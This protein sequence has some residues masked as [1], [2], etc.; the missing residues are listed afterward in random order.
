MRHTHS[1]LCP[2]F[3]PWRHG[4]AATLLLFFSCFAL[5]QHS[6]ARVMAVSGTATA[7]DANG[8]ERP[9]QKGGEVFSGDKVVTLD[10]ALVQMRLH[11]G[12][13]LSV[14]PGTTLVIDRFVLD[15]KN[16]ANSSFLVSLLRGGFRSITGLIGRTNPDAYQIRSATATIGIR[17]TDH[18]PMVVLPDT[19]GTASPDAPGLY[20][21]VNEGETFIRNQHGIQS[22][23]AGEVGFAS[24]SGEAAPR[25]MPKVPDF[26]KRDFRADGRAPRKGSAESDKEDGGRRAAGGAVR[27]ALA[28]RK[29]AAADPAAAEPTA[30]PGGGDA[31]P[32][33]TPAQKKAAIIQNVIVP[34]QKSGTAPLQK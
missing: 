9:L 12:G 7:T 24:H 29:D 30:S 28:T 6:A 4:L 26:Y 32:A 21:K 11:D 18:E 27:P 13:Y 19:P 25:L 15:E 20:D 1:L 34:Q 8:Q 22:L 3:S 10:A 2:P 16:T 23:K 14:R 5:A 31:S 17:G 33:L